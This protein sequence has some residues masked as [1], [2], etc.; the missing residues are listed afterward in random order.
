MQAALCLIIQVAQAAR[1]QHQAK[2]EAAQHALKFALYWKGAIGR[3]H[4]S[5]TKSANQ[6][7]GAAG[8]QGRHDLVQRGRE[9]QARGHKQREAGQVMSS[10]HGQLNVLKAYIERTDLQHRSASFLTIL[11]FLCLHCQ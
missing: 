3:A 1:Q 2:A 4:S 8:W 6:Q 7:L 11:N 5:L 9:R 10:Y